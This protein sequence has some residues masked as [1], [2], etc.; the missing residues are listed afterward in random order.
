MGGFGIVLF[1]HFLKSSNLTS[2]P[3]SISAVETL[4]A[5]DIAELWVKLVAAAETDPEARAF[6]VMFEPWASERIGKK[7]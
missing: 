7:S 5:G 1:P 4:N 6:L 2:I 3:K